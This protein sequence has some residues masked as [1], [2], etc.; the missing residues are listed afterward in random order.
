MKKIIVYPIRQLD[1]KVSLPEGFEDRDE[2]KI[3]IK[4]IRNQYVYFPR[5]YTFSN[6]TYL[7]YGELI[8]IANKLK[9]LNKNGIRE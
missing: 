3:K 4:K 2:T 9:E 1:Y 6:N 7:T 5:K 8:A